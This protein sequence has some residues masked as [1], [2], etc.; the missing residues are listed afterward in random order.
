MAELEPGRAQLCPATAGPPGTRHHPAPHLS[1]KVCRPQTKLQNRYYRLFFSYLM[2]K[3]PGCWL[4][5]R[6]GLCLSPS[7]Q[8]SAPGDGD[9]LLACRTRP[10]TPVSAMAAVSRSSN[11]FD[12]ES[13]VRPTWGPGISP[14]LAASCKNVVERKSSRGPG[15]GKILP[16]LKLPQHWQRPAGLAEQVF[17]GETLPSSVPSH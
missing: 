16:S 15:A 17:N 3:S 6:L 10:V 4:L 11:T 7:L 14:C 2:F 12:L 13:G 8:S 5:G 1:T 9:G